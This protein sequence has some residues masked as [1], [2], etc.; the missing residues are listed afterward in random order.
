MAPILPS[1]M[2][3]RHV[4]SP[5]LL[6]IASFVAMPVWANAIVKLELIGGDRGSAMDFQEWAQT[7]GKAG[8]RNVRLR[9][10]NETDRPDIKTQ[11]T[12]G[13]RVY[14]VTGVINARNELVLP[15]RRFRRSDVGRLKKWL[16]ELAQQGPVTDREAKG[17]FGLS[18]AQCDLVRKDLATPV[19][20]ATQG[21]TRRRVV[22]KIANPLKFSLELDAATAQALADQKVGEDLSGLS[23]GTALAYVLRPV[24]YC[25]VPRATGTSVVY[26]VVRAKPGLEIWPVGWAS[27]KSDRDALPALYEFRNVHVQ[28]VAAATA[29]SAI[30][31]RLEMPVLIDHN[32]LARHGINPAKTLVSL[33]RSRTT[34]SIALRKLLFQAGLKF[35]VRY[36]E[37]R[38]PLLWVT[39]IKPV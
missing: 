34:Y 1:I 4:L 35:E 6:A 7:L 25:L 32:A 21:V 2:N 19:G 17:P 22:T 33:P 11:G 24:G 9:S 8:I 37:A 38:T 14:V 26:A 3:V 15:G 23:S 36:D 13:N 18:T 12:A 30:G 5:L 27:E 39:T 28:N 10:G 16:D 31:Q 20:F 29:L